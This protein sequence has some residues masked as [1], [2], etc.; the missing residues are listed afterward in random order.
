[1]AAAVT[2]TCPDRCTIGVHCTYFIETPRGQTPCRE[3][4]DFGAPLSDVMQILF[5]D[6]VRKG[7]LQCTEGQHEKFRFLSIDIFVTDRQEAKK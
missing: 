2:R 1:M 6:Y 4:R 3:S 7:R 5:N